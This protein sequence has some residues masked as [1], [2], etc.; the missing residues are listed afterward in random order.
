M[1]GIPREIS[2]VR[3]FF[4]LS[5][6]S[7]CRRKLAELRSAGQPRAAVPTFVFASSQSYRTTFSISAFNS[8]Y[9]T[10]PGWYQATFPA[11]SSST[12]VGVVEAP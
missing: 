9:G 12:K 4:I 6:E 8:P 10:A 11:L 7:S 2:A 5:A 1:L 3:I